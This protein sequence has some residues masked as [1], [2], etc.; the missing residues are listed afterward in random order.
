MEELISLMKVVLASAFALYLKTH[1]FHW[2][3]EMENFPQYHEFFKGQYEEVWASID[4]LAEQIR[5][6]DAY[7]P[8]SMERFAALSKVTGEQDV[9]SPREMVLKLLH[10]H[11]VMIILLTEAFNMASQLNKQGLANFLG[12]RLEAHNKHRWMLRATAKKY[13]K[14]GE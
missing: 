9:P 10:D 12:G 7:A 1:N 5:Q 4:D 13:S 11:E 3:V 6:L 8:G 14:G 2:N